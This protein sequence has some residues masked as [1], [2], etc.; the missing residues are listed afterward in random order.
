VSATVGYQRLFAELKRRKVFRVAAVYGATAF[1][2]LQVADL[3]Q[4]G[5][6][7]PESFLTIATLLALFGFPIALVLAWAYERTPQGMRRT[8]DAAP[9]EISEI[10]AQPVAKRWPVGL[11]AAAGTALLLISAWWAV[12]RTS[13]G[14]EGART[15]YSSIAVLPFVNMSGHESDEYFSDG[16]SEELLNALT[17]VPGLK[18]AGRTSSFAYKGE[19]RDLR[20]IGETLGVETILEGSVRRAG[21]RVRVTAQLVGTED[22][23]HVWSQEWDR[24]LTAENVFDIQEEVA[25]AVV[26][27]MTT[28]LDPVAEAQ[29]G[30]PDLIPGAVRTPDLE[31]YDLYLLGRHRWATRTPEGLADAVEY[32][33]AALGRDSTYAPAWVGLAAAYNALPWYTEYSDREGADRSK[34]AALRALELDPDNAE[35]LYTLATTV[36][37]FERDWA[38]AGRYFERA[39]ELDPAYAQG[40]TWYCI[41]LSDVG[42]KE[43]GLPWCERAVELDPLSSHG[44]MS[45]GEQLIVMGLDEEGIRVHARALSIQPDIPISLQQTAL[46]QSRLGRYDEAE[47]NLRRW[48]VVNGAPGGEASASAVIAGLRDPSRRAESVA[49]MLGWREEPSVYMVVAWLILLDAT[50]EAL[51][52]VDF[53]VETQPPDLSSIYA[54]PGGERLRGE[55]RYEAALAALNI[56]DLPD[57]PERP[58]P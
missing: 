35:A 33:E 27:A 25:E 41:Y 23:F 44:L 4:E 38:E 56:P 13:A 34:R 32:F 37:E 29:P 3:L 53:I 40:L 20:E 11:A 6:R 14:E 42:R 1:V 26:L 24:E 22:G 7:L 30:P 9:G 2:A 43:E 28:G 8:P 18:V 47:R 52:V 58:A 39:L 21:G 54:L 57:P 19:S 55:P 36:Y 12:G 5:L 31:A 51:D 46:A 45:L 10:V 50:D 17:R 16:L 48:A 49:S 15:D